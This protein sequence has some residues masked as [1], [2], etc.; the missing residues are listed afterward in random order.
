MNGM[1]ALIKETLE[2]SLP[3]PP[4]EDTDKSVVCNLEESFDHA[5][6]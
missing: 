3:L 1:S 6:P 4:F 2:R 5:A